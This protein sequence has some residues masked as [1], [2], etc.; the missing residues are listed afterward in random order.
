MIRGM[1]GNAQCSACTHFGYCKIYW[2]PE[3]KRQGGDKIPLLKSAKEKFNYE[4]NQP[5][6]AKP[7]TESANRRFKQY[8]PIRTRVVYW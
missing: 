5:V 8:E 7:E 6:L 3:C 1:H 2:G 4:T